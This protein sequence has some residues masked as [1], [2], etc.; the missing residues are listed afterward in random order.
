MKRVAQRRNTAAVAKAFGQ[1]LS[2]QLKQPGVKRR[3][4]A[5]TAQIGRAHLHR[6]ALGRAQPT[7]TVFL[8]V[9]DAAELHPVRLM[10]LFYDALAAAS[11]PQDTTPKTGDRELE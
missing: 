1:V 5:A 9:A 3:G 10:R 8:G 4:F 2:D 11:R 6:L 7:L